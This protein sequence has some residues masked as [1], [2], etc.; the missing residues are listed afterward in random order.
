MDW[1]KLN[2]TANEL[3]ANMLKAYLING[4]IEA[5]I[6][7]DASALTGV[8]GTQAFTPWSVYVEQEKAAEAEELVREFFGEEIT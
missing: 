4:G 7:P 1:H 2:T 6:S 5:V 3:E 8:F